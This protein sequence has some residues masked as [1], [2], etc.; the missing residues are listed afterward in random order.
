MCNAFAGS[1]PRRLAASRR[2]GFGRPAFGVR[3][4]NSRCL[5]NQMPGLKSEVWVGYATFRFCGRAA[6]EA[7][8]EAALL[9][10]Q[11]LV[12]FPG[13]LDELEVIALNDNRIDEFIE[14]L[15]FF[16]GHGLSV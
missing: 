7:M 13:E 16:V 2:T 15:F 1:V 3:Y 10:V 9:A 8:H 4:L 12:E 14:T 11:K 5:Q 6:L